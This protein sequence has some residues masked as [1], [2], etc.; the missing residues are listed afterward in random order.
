MLREKGTVHVSELHLQLSNFGQFY[1]SRQK[2]KSGS[3]NL[4]IPEAFSEILESFECEQSRDERRKLLIAYLSK[5]LRL[6]CRKVLI[7]ENQ[8]NFWKQWK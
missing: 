7:I 3:R 1:Q 5:L 8:K 4:E 6:K 2:T